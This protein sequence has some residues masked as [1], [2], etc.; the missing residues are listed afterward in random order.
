M[1]FWSRDSLRRAPLCTC[2]ESR[3]GVEFGCCGLAVLLAVTSRSHFN[4]QLRA[5]KFR[6]TSR[7]IPRRRME[8]SIGQL[9]GVL[10]SLL[11]GTFSTPIRSILLF[12]F[13]YFFIYL[14]FFFCTERGGDLCVVWSAVGE[15]SP[16]LALKHKR[17]AVSHKLWYSQTEF[18]PT[19]P[20]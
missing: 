3:G 16:P 13:W 20:P 11:A 2:R 6:Q 7:G 8:L 4:S 1:A 15:R 12:E 5:G 9:C 19:F 14:F 10:F 17:A 18:E